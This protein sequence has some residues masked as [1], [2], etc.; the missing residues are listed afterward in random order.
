M[1]KYNMLAILLMIGLAIAACGGQESQTLPAE[2]P[3]A[4]TMVNVVA[5]K[6]PTGMSMVEIMDLAQ[7]HESRND[8]F[9]SVV[10]APDEA[11]AMLTSGQ[12]DIIGVPTN[13]AATLYQKTN[14]NVQLL[15]INTLGVLYILERNGETLN[16]LEDLKGKTLYA[17]GKGATP[18]YVINYLLSEK[19]LDPLN[20]VTIEYKSEHS[21]LATLLASGKIDYA[22][23]P[24]PFVTSVLMNSDT[25]RTALDLTSIWEEVVGKENP[26]VM[27]A[28]LVRKDFA[29][30]HPEAVIRFLED[31][32]SSTY[33]VNE[34]VEEAATLIGQ[35]EIMPEP[36]A[37][38]AIPQSN[39]V[40]LDGEEMRHAVETYLNILNQANP[41]S[42]GGQM[43][44][45]AFYFV[46]P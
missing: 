41:S 22:M 23:L 25:V 24:Q 20:D 46:Q 21:E 15:N 40:Y 9:F 28:T 45:D 17:T 34:S 30:T 29:E 36:V 32:K 35:F 42:I 11:V 14:G 38:M 31:L 3:E 43:P 33:F 1:K 27:G 2:E 44:D 6:G 39:M 12:A 4:K 26:L 10:G 16:S 37:K 18:E 19:G 7:K 5:L 13:L 8:Y